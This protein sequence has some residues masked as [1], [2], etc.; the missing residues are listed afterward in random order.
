M[1]Y[2]QKLFDISTNTNVVQ[3]C[4]NIFKRLVV[5]C[6]DNQQK[7]I[8]NKYL[9]QI[10]LKNNLPVDTGD[11]ELVSMKVFSCNISIISL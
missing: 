4:F 7:S 11:E 6:E 10:W 5:K 9:G 1:D 3:E 8:L 2:C